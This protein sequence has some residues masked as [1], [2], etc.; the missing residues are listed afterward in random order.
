MLEEG[1]GEVPLPKEQGAPKGTSQ[2]QEQ[3]QEQRQQGELRS[4][5]QDR[6]MVIEKEQEDTEQMGSSIPEEQSLVQLRMT[7]FVNP[8]PTR[9]GWPTTGNLMTRGDNDDPA[10]TR[11]SSSGSPSRGGEV[12]ICTVREDD[13]HFVIDSQEA[14][15]DNEHSLVGRHMID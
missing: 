10:A 7:G 2:E 13:E 1:W 11:I 3:E 9:Q 12:A 6:E 14:I 4:R 15:L 8:A 5:E